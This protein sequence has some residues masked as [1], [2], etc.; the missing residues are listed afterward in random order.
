MRR[1]R[2]KENPTCFSR[3]SVKL[4]FT[5]LLLLASC[6]P[7]A[8]VAKDTVNRV[9]RGDDTARLVALR[10]AEGYVSITFFAGDSDA[11]DP[12]LFIGSSGR[13]EVD[14]YNAPLCFVQDDGLGCKI[15]EADEANPPHRVVRAGTRYVVYVSGEGVTSSVRYYRP[16]G[17]KPLL[18]VQ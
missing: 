16:G 1:R 5:L 15:G 3:G 14:P 17:V 11:Q 2:E 4:L 12:T 18:V 6:A 9:G 8:N 7:V 13:L 10:E